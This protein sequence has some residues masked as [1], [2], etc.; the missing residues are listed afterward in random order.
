MN[1]FVFVV[2]FFGFDFQPC[3]DAFQEAVDSKLFSIPIEL[4]Q[5]LAGFPIEQ[6][7]AESSAQPAHSMSSKRMQEYS[8]EGVV[9]ALTLV[10]AKGFDLGSRVQVAVAEDAVAEAEDAEDAGCVFTLVNTTQTS[11]LLEAEAGESKRLEVQEF[12][13]TFVLAEEVLVEKASP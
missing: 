8:S 10:R 2:C 13:D 4:E 3:A 12:L 7:S 5:A 1:D 9:E 6:A 11:V